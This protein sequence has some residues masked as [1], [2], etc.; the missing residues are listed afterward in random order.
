MKIKK[1]TVI[2]I[3]VLSLLTI[4]V[5]LSKKTTFFGPN[6]VVSETSTTSFQ[7]VNGKTQSLNQY[8]GKV[9]I[10]NFWATWCPP[11]VAE[12]P[13]LIQLQAKYPNVQVI[14]ISVDQDKDKVK[15]FITSKGINYPVGYANTKLL[16][17][18]GNVSTIPTTYILDKNFKIV[19]TAIGFHSFKDFEAKIKPYL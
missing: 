19:D 11:C 16:K 6:P 7:L 5:S 8:K 18:F 2:A 14:G 13:S 3:S 1:S 9:I 12:I 4:G 17:E 15:S 10:L